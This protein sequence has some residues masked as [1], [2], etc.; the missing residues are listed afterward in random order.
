MLFHAVARISQISDALEMARAHTHTYTSVRQKCAAVSLPSANFGWAL[1]F[2]W[3]CVALPLFHPR[4][5]RCNQMH[6]LNTSRQFITLIRARTIKNVIS[7]SR[8]L[9]IRR[10]YQQSVRAPSINATLKSSTNSNL[11]SAQFSEATVVMCF[12][13]AIFVVF[14]CDCDCDCEGIVS[15]LDKCHKHNI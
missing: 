4:Y 5:H 15:N 12:Q 10:R 1:G 7:P 2:G 6:F 8:P 13:R 3:C 9:D 11:K 14:D